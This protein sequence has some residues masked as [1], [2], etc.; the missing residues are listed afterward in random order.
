M[1]KRKIAVSQKKEKADL[2]IT[3]VQV[4]DVFNLRWKKANIVITDRHI[5]A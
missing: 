1:M 5:I 4:A 3:N 2:I